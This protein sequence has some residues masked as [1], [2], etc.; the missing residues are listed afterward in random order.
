[1]YLILD[2]GNTRIKHFVYSGKALVASKVS[3]FSD[4]PESLNKTKQEF[5]KITAILI[6]DVW[7]KAEAMVSE[8]FTSQKI[9]ICNL[10]LKMPFTTCYETPTSFGADR[11][12]LLSAICLAYPKQ[13]VLGIDLGTCITYDFIDKNAKHHGGSLSLIHI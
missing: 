8:I 13:N 9:I 12:A 10:T 2:F 1:M 3:V 5:P 11:I 6:A 4:L 7:G